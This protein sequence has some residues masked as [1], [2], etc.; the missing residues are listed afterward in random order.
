VIDSVALLKLATP[1]KTK[2]AITYP[3]DFAPTK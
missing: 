3:L 1:Q 2:L